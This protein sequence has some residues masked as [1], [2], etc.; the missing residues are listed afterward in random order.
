[1]S[2][3]F[4]EGEITANLTGLA[5][6]SGDISGNTFSG[7]KASDIAHSSLDA[8]GEFTGKFRGGFYGIKAAE[9]GGIFDFTSEDQEDGAFR[10]AFGGDK[11]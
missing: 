10:G 6:L 5:T 3:K 7:T 2:A 4:G 1:M 11:D 8:E 9:A